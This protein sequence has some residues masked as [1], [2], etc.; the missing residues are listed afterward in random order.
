MIIKKNY[1][2]KKERSEYLALTVKSEETSI[3]QKVNPIM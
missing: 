1:D 3:I 2:L